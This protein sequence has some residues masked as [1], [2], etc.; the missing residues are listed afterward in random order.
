[1]GPY[2]KAIPLVLSGLV[3]F[4]MPRPL[5]PVLPRDGRELSR[6]KL[7]NVI[8]SLEEY[9][10]SGPSSQQQIAS[11]A[12]PASLLRLLTA[13]PASLLHL[14]TARPVLT[15]ACSSSPSSF[16]QRLKLST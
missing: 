16:S 5:L 13:A 2:F 3:G 10:S 1:M 15:L 7:V 9:Q 12:A 11:S 14:L 4:L 8:C 6:T